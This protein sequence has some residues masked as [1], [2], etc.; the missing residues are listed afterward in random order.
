MIGLFLVSA[1]FRTGWYASHDGIFHIYRTE[2]A[3]S[4]LKL[5]QFPLRWAGNFD[6]GFGIPLFTFVY[7]LPYYITSVI[8]YF[9]SSILAVKILTVGSYLLGGLGIFQLFKKKGTMLS[10]A[11]ALIYLMTPYQF[12]NIFVR[13]ALGEILAL[14]LM[15]WVLYSFSLLVEDGNKL[16][17]YHPLP[18]ALLLIAHNFLGIL[19]AVF[20]IGY[21]LFQKNQKSQAIIN[22]LI[23]FGLAS[24][25]LIPMIGEKNILYSYIHPDLNF[26]FDQHF[27]YFKQL[28]YG[29]WDYWYSLPG[30]DDGMSFQLGFAQII[31]ASLGIIYTIFNPKR[32]KLD[33]YLVL[34]YLG[35]ILL[36]LSR[37]F[38]IWHSVKI[39]QSIQF[40]WR[41]LFMPA[42]LTP[43]LAF[44]SLSAVSKKK[45][46]P[47]ILAGLLILNF[48]NIRNY[49]RP[50]KF[51]DLTEYTDLYRLYYN[52]TSTT[53]RTE[54]LPKWSVSKER[55]KTDEVLVNSG[56]MIINS[57]TNTPLSVAIEINNK[58]DPVPAKITILRNFYPGW[59]AIMDGK[60]KIE[61]APSEDG[62]IYMVPAI[63]VHKYD[64]EM[65]STN[66]EKLANIIS[67][68]SLFMIGYLWK[69]NQK[70]KN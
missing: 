9:T 14:G 52:K 15:P 47:Y 3:L 23:S 19:F 13:G 40:P 2:E 6:Q 1:I 24:F 20:L 55:F 18:L 54:I 69:R 51:F 56:N 16:K 27:V 7:P 30:P 68:A 38:P 5:W 22:L 57:L 64:I 10:F 46:F 59:V 12:L 35:S 53:F 34:A 49:R 33:I 61:L 43:L 4:M 25:F 67:L 37:S 31:L 36:M 42:I 32:T 60:E 44:K 50:I 45:Y 48:V 26:R 58:I 28:L 63:G 70:S 17:W 29:K 62:M 41:F 39:L 66:V 21:V 65:K 11:L 8:S